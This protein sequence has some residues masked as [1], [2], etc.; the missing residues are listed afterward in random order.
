VGRGEERLR[1]ILGRSPAITRLDYNKKVLKFVPKLK[2]SARGTGGGEGTFRG[3][4]DDCGLGKAYLKNRES[5][6]HDRK[7][8][9][10]IGGGKKA[11]AGAIDSP[12][13]RKQ[14]L[15][16]RCGAGNCGPPAASS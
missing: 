10:S 5:E 7:G 3:R 13:L 9:E 6:A 16:D 1:K 2:Q 15:T 12:I 14:P 11:D 4:S 8:E